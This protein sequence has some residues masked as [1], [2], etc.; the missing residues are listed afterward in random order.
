MEENSDMRI[1]LLIEEGLI[2][3]DEEDPEVYHITLEGWATAFLDLLM[4]HKD[5]CFDHATE[6]AYEEGFMRLLIHVA[7]DLLHNDMDDFLEEFG[8]E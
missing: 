3:R 6:I 5:M 4:E 2:T 8:G 1:D 7:E